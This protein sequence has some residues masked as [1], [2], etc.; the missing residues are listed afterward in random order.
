MVH[1]EQFYLKFS[2]YISKIF[3]R[4][5]LIFTNISKYRR[6]ALFQADRTIAIV[7]FIYVVDLVLSDSSIQIGQYV[8]ARCMGH[9]FCFNTV[10]RNN[11]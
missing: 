2:I 11:S 8:G 7:F 4:W 3:L 6:K 1:G 5:V 9:E 10:L